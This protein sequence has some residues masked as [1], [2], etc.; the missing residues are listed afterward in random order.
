MGEFP[1][2]SKTND[3]V[4]RNRSFSHNDLELLDLFR[5]TSTSAYIDRRRWMPPANGELACRCRP[6]FRGSTLKEDA[7]LKGH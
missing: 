4:M 1:G 5:D 2:L 3:A 6:R 7:I